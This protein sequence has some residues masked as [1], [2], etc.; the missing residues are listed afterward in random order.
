M[1]RGILAWLFGLWPLIFMNG[2]AG[3]GLKDMPVEKAFAKATFAGGCFWC[4]ES[5]FDQLPGVIST[6]SGYT[7]GSKLNPTYEEVSAG[8]TGHAEAVQVVYDPAKVSYT[9]LLQVFWRNIDPTVKDRQFCDVGRQY[10]T[11]IFYYTEEQRRLAEE[12][13][14]ALEK[15]KSFPE[16]LVTEI[17]AASEFYPAEDY[18]QDYYKKNPIRY[19]YYRYSCGRDERLEQLWG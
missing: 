3:G 17:T 4:M 2:S 11:A 14:A 5:P 13:R 6:T 9:E 12:S 16:P 10:R 8:G 1:N 19:K 7:G 15:T 18:H